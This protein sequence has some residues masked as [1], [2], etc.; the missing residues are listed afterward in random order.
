MGRRPRPVGE[1]ITCHVVACGNSQPQPFTDDDD[2]AEFLEILDRIA[3][4]QRWTCHAYCVLDT[5]VH[6]LVTGSS[7]RLANG[8]RDLLGRYARLF[9]RRHRRRGHVFRDRHRTFQ[10]HTRRQLQASAHGIFRAPIDAGIVDSAVSWR[11]SSLRATLGIDDPGCIFADHLLQTFALNQ[12]FARD[13]LERYVASALAEPATPG[14]V[15]ASTLNVS[16]P[17]IIGLASK[18]IQELLT[19]LGDR[20]GIRACLEYGYLRREIANALGVSEATISR[21]LRRSAYDDL[22]R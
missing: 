1:E 6:L 18:S 10:V 12:T 17:T 15:W 13:R 21:R 3:I 7:T 4:E 19:S 11:W 8:M 9:N 2:R 22:K 16:R 14:V 5:H 20:D